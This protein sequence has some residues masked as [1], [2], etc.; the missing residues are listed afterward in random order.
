M[1]ANGGTRPASVAKRLART[2]NVGAATAVF[3]AGPPRAKR[4][5]GRCGGDADDQVPAPARDRGS[6]SAAPRHGGGLPPGAPLGPPP[7]QPRHHPPYTPP[8]PPP[9]PPTP[10]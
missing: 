10:P 7:P 5:A 8:S 6:V 1:A 4:D 2:C 3:K 9:S